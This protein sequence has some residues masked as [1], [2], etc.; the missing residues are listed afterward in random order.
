MNAV[1]LLENKI[2]GV[3]RRSL[4]LSFLLPIVTLI[5]GCIG[6]S[7]F[8]TITP[9]E[10]VLSP[11]QSLRFR[12]HGRKGARVWSVNGLPQ[13]ASTTGTISAHGFYTA[14]AAIGPASFNTA[15][16]VSVVVNGA[17][18]LPVPVSLFLPGNFT[19]GTVSPTANSL[20]ASY[21]IAAPE[22]ASVQ[23]QFGPDTNYGLTTWTQPAP[24]PGGTVTILVAGMRASSIYHMRAVVQLED[25]TQAVDADHVFT[26]GA[27]PADRLPT[28][29]VN[30]FAEMAP[31]S[32]I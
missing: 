24:A 15:I 12:V 29:T 32:G 20:V 27:V 17:P 19:P 23:V 7:S 25:G 28:I 5:A 1:N 18:S 31:R 10:A 13:G 4:M 3:N 11:G 6:G 14:P 30:Q 21:S 2:L 9:S 22:G 16:R 8:P 26:T